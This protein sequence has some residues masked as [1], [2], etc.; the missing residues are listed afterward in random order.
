MSSPRAEPADV[1]ASQ[2]LEGQA[3]PI[4]LDEAPAIAEQGLTVRAHGLA[5]TTIATVALLFALQWAQT[6]CLALLLGIFV[7]YSLNPV[8]TWLQRCY[9]PR[10]LAV[11]VVMATM[12]SLLIFGSYALREQ[13]DTIIEGVPASVARIS[14]SIT[15]AQH[16]GERT[17]L[18]K[19]QAAGHEIEKATADVSP[20]SDRAQLVVAQASN[21]MTSFLWAGSIGVLG[22]LGQMTMV[23]FLVFFL[24]LSGD[25]F[26]RKIV[27]LAGPTFARKKITVQMLDQINASIQRY[28][29]L[30]VV[31]NSLVMVLSW[32][33][34]AWAGLENA[35]AWAAAA[36]LLHII[37]YLG[38]TA[39]AGITGLAAFLQFGSWPI[40]IAIASAS[41]GIALV[42]GILV[43]TWM[44]GRIAKM[45]TTAVF[46]ALLFFGW[47]W[48]IGGMFL[49]I[50]LVV[51]IK[52][53]AEHFAPLSSVAELLGE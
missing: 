53:V 43:T 45:N 30:L 51:I 15:G 49:S 46:V 50:P 3:P 1:I 21:K 39:T 8:V 9:L 48:G 38:T 20:P 32:A 12:L 23:T 41:L 13:V 24:L 10:A 18:Q 37:P 36:G 35:G 4:M 5:L 28:M 40:A 25:T 27:R 33:V 16:R 22:L 26:K 11:S 42:V 44:T 19:M 29:V 34:F 52:V 2:A 31:T 17:T 14:A 6:F 7:A 47:M